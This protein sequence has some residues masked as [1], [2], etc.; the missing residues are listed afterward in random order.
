MPGEITL[1]LVFND[2]ELVRAILIMQEDP[3]HF[4]DRCRD[5]IVKPALERINV[6]LQQDNDPD[7]LA[8]FLEH[9]LVETQRRML[10]TTT[11]N[12]DERTT[13]TR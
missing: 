5:E 4:H 2:S 8:Y 9:A 11:E 10:S 13:P 6:T 12:Q 7:W 3:E 1:G